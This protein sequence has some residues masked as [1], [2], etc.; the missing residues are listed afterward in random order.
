L[1]QERLA[2]FSRS[3]SAMVWLDGG[4]NG[5]KDT[6]ITN[7]KILQVRTFLKVSLNWRILTQKTQV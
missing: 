1:S 5:G 3:I 7:Q 6:W 2:E 4:H